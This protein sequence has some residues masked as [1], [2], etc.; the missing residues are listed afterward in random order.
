MHKSCQAETL[1]ALTILRKL[2][3]TSLS[4]YTNIYIGAHRLDP[5][6]P[7]YIV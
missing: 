1:G 7:L 5:L 3:L 6:S 2:K 4:D